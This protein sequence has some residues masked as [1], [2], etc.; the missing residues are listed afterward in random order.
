MSCDTTSFGV[1]NLNSRDL[2]DLSSLDIE[3]ALCVSHC[4]KNKMNSIAL[5]NVMSRDV[6]NGPNKDGIC[7]LS[8]EPL[9]LIER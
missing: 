3:E 5:L 1:M 7:Y 2:P 8:V 6:Y 4:D 9:R